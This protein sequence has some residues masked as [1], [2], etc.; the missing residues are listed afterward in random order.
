MLELDVN[1]PEDLSALTESLRERWGGVDGALHAIAFAPEDALGGRFLTAPAESAAP[2][3]RR[4][5]SR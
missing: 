3:S 1:N 5:R 4:A 2:R